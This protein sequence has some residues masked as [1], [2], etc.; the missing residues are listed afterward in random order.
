VNWSR[1]GTA[2][3]SRGTADALRAAVGEA[4]LDP[5]RVLGDADGAMSQP[6][7]AGRHDGFQRLQQISPVQGKLR[8]AVALFRR[9]GHLDP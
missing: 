2:R 3:R 7:A 4:Q 1:A 6:N 5:V 9:V 8:R